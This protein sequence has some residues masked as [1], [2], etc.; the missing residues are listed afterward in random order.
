MPTPARSARI[1]AFL[2]RAL[3]ALF[4]PALEAAGPKRMLIVHSF[5][6]DF[7]PYDVIALR[8][9]TSV[10]GSLAMSTVT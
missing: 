8:T 3:L 7:A 10:A 2:A 9:R 4:A 5:G 6:R 1:H